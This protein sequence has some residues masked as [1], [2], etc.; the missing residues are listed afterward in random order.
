MSVVPELHNGV[1]QLVSAGIDEKSEFLLRVP[2]S[3]QSVSCQISGGSGSGDADLYTRWD[4]QVD[5][6]NKNANAVRLLLPEFDRQNLSARTRR[7]EI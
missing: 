6:D 2:S 3:M 5:F 1:P 4:S 7:N